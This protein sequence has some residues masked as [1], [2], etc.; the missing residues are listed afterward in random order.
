MGFLKP[1]VPEPTQSAPPPE[2]NDA[3]TQALAAAQRERFYGG[4]AGRAATQLTGGNA[5]TGRYSAAAQL[6][7][8]V[9]R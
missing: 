5:S 2:R 8:S 9:G 4:A 7:G 3:E 6:L 1:K